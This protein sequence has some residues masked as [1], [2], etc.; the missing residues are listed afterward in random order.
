MLYFELSSLS[1]RLVYDGLSKVSKTKKQE[2]NE[3]DN[4]PLMQDN[5]YD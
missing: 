2:T 5:D 3:E 4:Q 1:E